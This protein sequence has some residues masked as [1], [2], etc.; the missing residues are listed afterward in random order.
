MSGYFRFHLKYGGKLGRIPY[1]DTLS[2]NSSDA[3]L[4]Y[5]QIGVRAYALYPS[6]SKESV[7][8]IR[9]ICWPKGQ[10]IGLKLNLSGQ[11]YTLVH[12][13][14]DEDEHPLMRWVSK[15]AT[16]GGEFHTSSSVTRLMKLNRRCQL[17]VDPTVRVPRNR[18]NDAGNIV[19][20]VMG[21]QST[22]QMSEAE[23]LIRSLKVGESI[24]K[25]GVAPDSVRR[26]CSRWNKAIPDRVFASKKIDGA[27]S[28]VRIR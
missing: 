10:P 16:C 6:L 12:V 15:C 14:S 28:I 13:G 5:G 17:H 4:T 7:M 27:F 20:P 18:F 21:R 9:E 24:R 23:K 25:P 11:I 3:S 2:V 1:P 19:G 8:Q 22:T 26:S